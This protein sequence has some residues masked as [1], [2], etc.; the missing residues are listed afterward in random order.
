MSQNSVLLEKP[1]IIRAISDALAKTGVFATTNQLDQAV[2]DL[3]GRAFAAASNGGSDLS[4]TSMIRALQATQ[5]HVIAQDTKE[6]DLKYLGQL[7]PSTKSLGSQSTPGSYLIDQRQSSTIVSMLN[8]LSA[9]RRIGPKVWPMGNLDSL[10]IPTATATPTA[11]WLSQNAAQTPSDPTLSF[12]TLVPKTIRSLV[13]VSNELLQVSDPSVDQVV[14]ELTAASFANLESTAFF[15]TATVSGAPVSLYAASGTSSISSA[16]SANGGTIT[17]NDLLRTMAKAYE[18]DATPPF[19]W[20][21]SATTF[22]TSILNM[23]DTTSRPIVQQNAAKDG[24]SW[25]LF[26]YPVILTNFLPVNQNFGSGT[27]K[28]FGAFLNP[29]YINM[30]EGSGLE[31]MTSSEFYFSSNATAIRGVR[32]VTWDFAPPQG[33]TLIKGIS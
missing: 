29:A 23:I 25:T 17:Y 8:E 15:S 14:S 16:N 4:I 19:V 13:Q 2:S 24:I 10:R 28:T 26:G 31:I 18:V 6:A 30:G 9:L 12:I 5:G 3:R 27:N 11:E 33:I 21:F 1:E 32:R 7:K 22:L 20:I